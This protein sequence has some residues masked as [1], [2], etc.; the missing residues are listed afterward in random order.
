[1]MLSV[2]HL[3]RLF[4]EIST[5]TYSLGYSGA[6]VNYADDTGSWYRGYFMIKD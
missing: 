4:I 6:I 3:H 2:K 1:M 5:Y